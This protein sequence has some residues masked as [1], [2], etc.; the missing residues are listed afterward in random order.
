[1]KLIIL[2]GSP[3]AGKSTLAEKL[4]KDFPLSLLA[5]VDEWRRL[6]SGWRENREK[7]LK[8]S[9]IFMVAAVDAYLKTGHDVIVDKAIVSHDTVIDSLI[10][11]G[12]EDGAEVYEFILTADKD[13]ISDRAEKRGF[14]E[15]GLLTP[16]KVVELWE[17][18]QRLIADR[19]NAVI[20]DTSSITAEEVYEKV[21]AVIG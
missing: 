14:H 3:A 8:L 15:N 13:I 5:D 20:I 9:Y 12:K 19:G 4:H 18:T 1:M 10:K 2:N 11:S 16:E 21:K 7:S 17:K 6:I